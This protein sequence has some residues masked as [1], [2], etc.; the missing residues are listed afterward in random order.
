MSLKIN[1]S[2][3]EIVDKLTILKI[4]KMKIN[5]L[6]KLKQIEIEYSFLY[7]TLREYHNDKEYLKLEKMLFNINLELWEIEDD[8]RIK[9]KNKEFDKKFIDL[10]RSVY[11]TNDERFKVKSLVN[12]YFNSEIREVKSYCS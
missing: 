12:D 9:E 4:K 8:I 2:I 5:D 3:G 1:V 10:A 6:E 11:K 7:E